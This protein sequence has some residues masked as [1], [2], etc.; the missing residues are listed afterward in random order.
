VFYHTFVLETYVFFLLPQKY[1]HNNTLRYTVPVLFDELCFVAPI[2][3]Q[4]SQWRA[5]FTAFDIRLW[6]CLAATFVVALGTWTLIKRTTDRPLNIDT[7]ALQLFQM[8]LMVPLNRLPN[9]VPERL[10]IVSTVLFGFI[11]ATSLQAVMVKYLSYPKYERNMATPQ[12]V[13]DSGMP[14]IVASNNLIMMFGSDEESLFV[15]LS[16]RFSISKS[17]DILMEVAQKRVTEY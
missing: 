10:M 3:Q 2:A 5:V 7:L 6:Y 14:I 15:K 16:D 1:H 11:T 9:N 8:F 13:Y 12:D 4:M 17:I